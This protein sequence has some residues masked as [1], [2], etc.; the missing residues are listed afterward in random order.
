MKACPTLTAR[1]VE[2]RG[3]HF[4]TCRPM[5]AGQFEDIDNRIDIMQGMA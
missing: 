5:H 1:R 4:P 2:R 3:F